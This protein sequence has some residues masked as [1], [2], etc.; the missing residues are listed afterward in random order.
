MDHGFIRISQRL[1]KISNLKKNI[2]GG[3]KV[4]ESDGY[5]AALPYFLFNDNEKE[6]KKVIK[7]VANSRINEKYA[8][9]KLKIIE[10][11]NKKDRNPVQSFVKKNKKNKYFKDVITN[12]KKVLRLKK[13][14]HIMT[15]RKFGKACSYPGTF[16]GSIH[17]IIT[18]NNYKSAITK[19]IKAGG[20]NCSRANF[21]GAYF[22]ALKPNSIPTSWIK[23][24]IPANEII[25]RI[26]LI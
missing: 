16:M 8:L 13:Q 21:V 10:L 6:L 1:F 26:G 24:T 2:T 15:V 22:A 20:C 3:T 12:I 18:S 19:T 14:N 7:S 9:S 25:K 17:A 4:N 11:A 23:K 5:C